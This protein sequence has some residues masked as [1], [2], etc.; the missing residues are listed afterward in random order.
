[1]FLKGFKE[2]KQEKFMQRLVWGVDGTGIHT[3]LRNKVLRV[4]F[5]YSLPK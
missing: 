1:M 5:P 3:C 4:R 2:N